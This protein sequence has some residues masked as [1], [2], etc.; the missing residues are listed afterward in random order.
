MRSIRSLLAVLLLALGASSASAQ[1][2]RTALSQSA[3]T[4]VCAAPCSV[5][6][7]SGLVAFVVDSTPPTSIDAPAVSWSP[8]N[9]LFQNANAG[10]RIYARAISAGSS[11]ASIPG[12]SASSAPS[13]GIGSTMLTPMLFS[14]IPSSASGMNLTLAKSGA[15]RAS[16]YQGCN[17]TATTIYM[18]IYDTASTSAVTPGTTPVTAGPYP[19][20]ANTCTPSTTFAANAGIMFSNGLVYAFGASPDDDDTTGIDPGAIT[21]FQL[22]YQ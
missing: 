13:S 19:F 11:V 15:G 22:G 12:T 21:A 14:R 1:T 10:S 18:R 9:G 7:L 2:T 17:T 5:S 16:A 4:D 3:W 6:A 8:E 20:P